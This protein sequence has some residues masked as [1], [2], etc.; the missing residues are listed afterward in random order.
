MCYT[1]LIVFSEDVMGMKNVKLLDCT[2]RDGGY[3]NDWEFGRN[4]MI[5]VFE[6]LVDSKTDIIEIGFLDERRPFDF[7]RSIGP[8]TK[9]LKKI[10]G[11]LFKKPPMVVGMIDYGTCK[12]ENL[13]PASESFLDGIRVIFKKQK[14]H[15]AMEYCKKVKQ[16]GYKVFSQ[17][18]SI[19]S[20]ND[21]ELLELTKLVNEVEPYAV[22]IVDTYG[23]LL[24]P[25][26]IHYADLL[27][28]NINSNIELGFHAH[29]NFQMAFAN[30]QAF[31][32]RKTNRNLVVDGTLFGMG[33]S[34]GNAPLELLAMFLNL[35]FKTNYLVQPMLE[36][37][38]ESVLPI[39]N[40]TSW[41]YKKFFYMTA[42]NRCHPNYLSF[43]QKQGNLTQTDLYEL[44]ERIEPEEKKLLYDENLAKSLYETF[45]SQKYP[46]KDVCNIIEK[47]FSNRK[48]LILGPGKN[49][50]FQEN[51]IQNFIKKENP[52]VISVNFV[53]KAFDVR[54]TFVTK[55]NRYNEMAVDL[56]ERNIE[57]IAT[58]NIS[59]KNNQNSI[60]VDKKPLLNDSLVFE[61]NS[62]LML[63]RL[64]LKS[65][66][67]EVFCAG[68]D[69]Y[70]SNE[71]NY[72]NPKMEYDFLKGEANALNKHIQS[73]IF[74]KLKDIHV[75]FITYS[76]YCDIEDSDS[77]AY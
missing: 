48:L 49:I 7:N 17:L 64:L 38:E 54:F 51:L 39:Y 13:E 75:N 21:D 20:Y 56:H 32:L 14:M 46:F 77:A 2:L 16:L 47:Q 59:P 71:T 1:A 6:R 74:N 12:I 10:W 25:Q 9:S 65:N 67:K 40:K 44:M 33:K 23:L 22:S 70:S 24:P 63:L 55:M 35:N 57:I 43:F 34:A 31:L 37:I 5:S 28:N 4:A 76:H 36:A 15:E 41:G 72:A 19:T 8:D 53:P 52:I 45:V 62:F 61:D 42:S 58:S 3:I 73:I 11:N 50:V 69:G 27:D 26:L 29:N 66:I 18:V 60:V 30:A 68:F